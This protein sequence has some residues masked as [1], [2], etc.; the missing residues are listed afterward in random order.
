MDYS[1]MSTPSGRQS[2]MMMEE[3]FQCVQ[4][5][6]DIHETSADPKEFMRTPVGAPYEVAAIEDEG[7]GMVASRDIK[8]EEIILQ[9]EP[10]AM[11][12][13]KNPVL[14]ILLTLPRKAL[15]AILLL[16][17]KHLG[18]RFYSRNLD[19]PPRRLL[20]FLLGI[21][22]TNHVI[23]DNVSGSTVGIL[24]LRGSLFNHSDT[25]NVARTYDKTVGK[26]IFTSM[27]D[28]KKGEELEI[29][30]QLRA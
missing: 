4:R 2:C 8:A 24:L 19:T 6:W 14:F 10:V 20:D 5:T 1:V 16:H 26:I 15:E 18:A 13:F 12:P 30:H 21:M 22:A 9:E 3:V 28:I 29:N 7:R 23:T 27:K 17:N 25:P 11:L